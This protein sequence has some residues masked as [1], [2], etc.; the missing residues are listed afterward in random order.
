MSG[1]TIIDLNI[2]GVED[3]IK[4]RRR[5]MGSIGHHS[6]RIVLVHGETI[7]VHPSKTF[8]LNDH[9]FKGFLIPSMILNLITRDSIMVLQIGLSFKIVGDSIL[10]RHL[11]K[12]ILVLHNLIRIADLKWIGTDRMKTGLEWRPIG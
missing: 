1:N 4:D 10:S 8:I 3:L 6:F 9:R 11:D 2:L 5:G 7:G 12:T